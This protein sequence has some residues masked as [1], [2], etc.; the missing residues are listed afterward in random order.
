MAK[1]SPTPVLE[2]NS[3]LSTAPQAIYDSQGNAST[4]NISTLNSSTGISGVPSYANAFICAGGG[5][6][7]QASLGL[8][9]YVPSGFSTSYGNV[10]IQ[11]TDLDN[12]QARLDFLF[13]QGSSSTNTVFTMQPSG[14]V[15]APG[16]ANL[17]A[18]GTCAPLVVDSFG[19][20]L[21]GQI[22]ATMTASV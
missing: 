3:Q 14:A 15:Q 6:G 8:A 5:G 20:I 11:A 9:T 17:P 19:N 7:A 10:I 2:V 18:A 21:V 22:T 1:T 13:S 16:L 12:G 4:L